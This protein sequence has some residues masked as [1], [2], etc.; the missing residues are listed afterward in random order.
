MSKFADY[1]T[2]GAFRVDLTKRMVQGL[3][4]AANGGPFTS[5]HYGSKGLM[6]RGLVEAV[7]NPLRTYVFDLKIT[8]AGMAVARLCEMA[9]LGTITEVAP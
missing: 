1:A 5:G 8:E 9:G 7:D 3:F 6:D 4:V 2:S